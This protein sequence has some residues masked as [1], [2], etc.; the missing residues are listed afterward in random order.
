MPWEV[1][2]WFGGRDLDEI[3][4]NAE[5]VR[6]AAARAEVSTGFRHGPPSMAMDMQF[7]CHD[8]E[9]AQALLDR[10]LLACSWVKGE[11]QF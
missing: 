1:N 11:V 4:D 6:T 2:V 7:R 8:A 9:D 3:H 5:C 10:V